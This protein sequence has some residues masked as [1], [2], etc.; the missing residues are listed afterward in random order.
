[1]IIKN[2]I[3][4]GR[5][6]LGIEFGSTRVKAVL[7]DGSSAPI[8]S[9]A[10]DWENRLENGIWT[11]P[12][13]LIHSALQGAYAALAEDVA[14]RYGVKLTRLAGL[15]ISGMMHG[16]MPFD[17]EG[18]LLV[19]FRTWRNTMT[20]A[21]AEELSRELGF[22]IPQRWSIA[23]LYQAVLCGEEHTGSIAY[24]NTLAGYI[25]FLLTGRREAGIGEA[26]GIFPIKD[27]DYNAEYLAKT[28]TL[29]S[30]KGFN[31]R[32]RD[33]LPEVRLAGAKGAVL[34]EEGA[35]LLDPTGTLM[36]GVPVCPPEGDAGTGMTA[37]NSVRRRTG[38]ISAGT[39]IFSMLVLDKPLSAPHED[40]DIVT[41]PDGSDVAM[42]HCNNCCSEIDMWVRM[43]GEF[44]ELA[45]A[46]MDKSALY[47]TLYKNALAAPADCCGAA[48]CN[49]I[50]G[51]PVAHVEAGRPM[52]TREPDR[53]VTLGGFFRA[54]LYSTFAT[55]RLGNEVLFKEENVKAERFNGHGG[56]FKVAGV[57][58]Q[59][60]ADALGVPVAVM[61]TAG[62]GGAWGMA[63]LAQYVVMGE[64]M[65]LADWLDEK[66]F[67]S[68][69]AE[70]SRPEEQGAKGFEEFMRGYKRLL[71]YE[72]N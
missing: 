18:R 27:M 25:H 59:L 55:L 47:E 72:R 49:F 9:G 1:M 10:F 54:Q 56:L 7:I 22:N 14:A 29:F 41:T 43:F 60:M 15:G 68:A 38:N 16:Y 33:V 17:S 71:G 36:P 58:S 34:T 3:S 65:S 63:L 32:L 4:E 61:T 35:R 28:E 69:K 50:S 19:P 64:G 52:Y 31:R 46:P 45:G 39:S 44:A 6:F 42:V 8:A 57:A 24:I 21:A 2:E 30:A 62:E 13:E 40:I 66:V 5:S 70:V 12:L 20:A 37:T 53:A 51:E 67:A 48:A 11:Y 23:H 26:S